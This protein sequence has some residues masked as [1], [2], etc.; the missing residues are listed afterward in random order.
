MRLVVACLTPHCQ[1]LI[2]VLASVERA[3]LH[4]VVHKADDWGQ[5]GQLLL[6]LPAVVPQLPILLPGVPHVIQLCSAV[7]S[8]L[9]EGSCLPTELDEDKNKFLMAFP[10][11]ISSSY[12]CQVSTKLLKMQ[13]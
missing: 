10:Q 7:V 6:Q 11:Q 2:T 12:V 3:K 5:P 8:R 4:H 1:R 9:G 13:S